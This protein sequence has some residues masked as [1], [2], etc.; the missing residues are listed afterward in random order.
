MKKHSYFLLFFI[1]CNSSILFAQELD[2]NFLDS[3]PAEVKGDVLD[4]IS[5]RSKSSPSSAKDYDSFN[6]KLKLNEENLNVLKRFG[7]DF[8][9][10]TPSTFMPINDPVA[11]SNYILDVDDKLLVQLIGDRS[12][13]YSYKI[14]RSGSIA[15]QDIGKITIAGLSL[16]AANAML[17]K[18][19]KENFIETEAVLSLEEIRDIEILITGQVKKPG[20]YILSGYSNILHAL[21]MAGGVSKYGSLREVIIKSPNKDNKSI[22]LYDMFVYADT[23]S[24]FSLRSGDS[25]FVNSSKNYVPIIGGVANEAIYEFKK[26]ETTDDLINYAGG[27]INNSDQSKIILSRLQDGKLSS[28]KL[29][30]STKLMVNDR[31]F[32]PFNEFSPDQYTINNEEIFIDEPV[33]ISG[34]VMNPG[35]YFIK[36]GDSLL[37]LINKVGG[38]KENAYPSAASLIN[39][40]AK[41]IE[42]SYNE[43]LYNEAIKSI[44]SFSSISSGV[45]LSSLSTILAEFKNAPSKGRIVSEFN[46]EAIQKDKSLDTRLMP[47]DEIHIPYFKERVYI[48]GEVLNPGTFKHL[49]GNDVS[50]YISSAGGLNKYADKQALIIVHPNGIV[51]RL[52]LRKFGKQN[53][54]IIKPGT[55]IYVPRNLQFIEGTQLAKVMAP[56]FS[57]LAISLASLNSISNN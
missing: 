53:S 50:K 51:E 35:K 18:V 7:D 40:D 27:I 17:N 43:K 2:Q 12:D 10:N 9:V 44:A 47:G 46:I 57:S 52:T 56:I 55:V 15:I 20:I 11:N 4:S 6:S 8:F 3:L 5:N 1:F 23:S 16:N 38:Y 45:D 33:F 42:R 49:D 39:K 26:G 28:S 19:L 24:N 32:I 14:D 13:Q 29:D 31:I 30:K 22:D 37:N 41:Q 34:A 36:P 54:T 25:I 48:F 21:I